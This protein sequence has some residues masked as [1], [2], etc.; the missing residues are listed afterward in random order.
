MKT[1]RIYSLL[2]IFILVG[3]ISAQDKRGVNDHV[4]MSLS[5][6]ISYAMDHNDGIEAAKLDISFQREFKKGATEIPKMT[7]SYTQGQFN[8]IYKYDNS[9]NLTQ[10]I[11]FPACF[12]AHNAVGNSLISSSKF[13]LEAEK[14]D[15]IF[16]IKSTYYALLYH[17]EIRKLL[18][19]EDSIYQ[20]FAQ[21]GKLKFES[22]EGSLLEKTTAESKVLE[23]KNRILENEEDVNGFQIELQTLLNYKKQVDAVSEDLTKNPLL[24][25]SDSVSMEKH[26]QL[27]YLAQQIESNHKM[28]VLDLYHIFIYLIGYDLL[29]KSHLLYLSYHSS[30]VFF[31]S[32]LSLFKRTSNLSRSLVDMSFP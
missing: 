15:L 6:C 20:S 26:P 14:A 28:K 1:R 13:K 29:I 18:Q 5:E 16:Q 23:I 9:F 19:T 30:S 8:S 25:K 10:T 4:D 27:L 12:A 3:F 7:V 21:A 31:L 22:G 17:Y 2:S 32:S 24:F 11:P